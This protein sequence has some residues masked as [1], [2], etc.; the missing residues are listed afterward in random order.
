MNKLYPFSGGRN[1]RKVGRCER[2]WM[3]G[4]YVRVKCQ[5][6]SLHV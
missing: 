4:V 5:M 6:T 2:F 1:L 3:A